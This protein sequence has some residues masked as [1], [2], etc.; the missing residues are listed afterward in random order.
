[1]SDGSR[2]TLL[3]PTV[4]D[5]TT[6][7]CYRIPQWL[8]HPTEKITLSRAIIQSYAPSFFFSPSDGV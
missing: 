1:M 2:T 8:Y 5:P 4:H 3:S 7:P 6:V